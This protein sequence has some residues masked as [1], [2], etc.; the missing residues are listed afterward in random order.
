MA[1]YVR[2]VRIENRNRD[3]ALDRNLADQEHEQ[4]H[5]YEIGDYLNDPTAS[6]V[7][8]YVSKIVIS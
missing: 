1:D 5:D 8:S 7:V 2:R 6:W 3:R 4:D